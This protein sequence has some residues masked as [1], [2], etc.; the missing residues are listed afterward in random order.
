ME[1]QLGN[2]EFN[3]KLGGAHGPFRLLCHT[4]EL[5]SIQDVVEVSSRLLGKDGMRA[6]GHL[7]PSG[8]TRPPTVGISQHPTVAGSAALAGSS[9]QPP[10]AAAQFETRKRRL[11]LVEYTE[12]RKRAS[13][14]LPRTIL[15]Y[16]RMRRHQCGSQLRISGS[17]WRVPGVDRGGQ[18]KSFEESGG[19]STG[20]K[21]LRER[22]TG[23]IKSNVVTG[24]YV[25]MSSAG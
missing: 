15:P 2:V 12:R 25:N 21:G 18:R 17:S 23:G 8:E 20:G 13:A 1:N 22:H 16:I 24:C 6:S 19:K 4:C 3:T 11:S 14:M 9:P 5:V 7:E 10:T